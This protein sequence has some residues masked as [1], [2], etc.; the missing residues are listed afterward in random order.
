M[1]LEEVNTYFINNQ[2]LQHQD[3]FNHLKRQ[4]D[5]KKLTLKNDKDFT[6]DMGI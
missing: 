2:L 1:I 6:L 3:Y 4:S 5:N